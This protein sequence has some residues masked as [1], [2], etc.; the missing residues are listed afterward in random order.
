M[1]HVSGTISSYFSCDGTDQSILLFRPAMTATY[2]VTLRVS[3]QLR[4][5]TTTTFTASGHAVILLV[6]FVV[7]AAT[8]S[9]L[10]QGRPVLS[11][12]KVGRSS[13]LLQ[14]LCFEQ[15]SF[16]TFAAPGPTVILLVSLI[17]LHCF[18]L[19]CYPLP[20]VTRPVFSPSSST[21]LRAAPVLHWLLLPCL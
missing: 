11:C 17:L 19:D 14:A 8:H 6:P 9:L 15:V 10:L 2:R 16:T 3:V 20:L 5:T 7:T 12:Y 4:T 13:H 21:L 1:E 18:A